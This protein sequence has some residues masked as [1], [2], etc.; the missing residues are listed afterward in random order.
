VGASCQEDL[1][2]NLNDIVEE[3]VGAGIILR[4]WSQRLATDLQ[5]RRD[6]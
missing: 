3:L 4:N 2:A 5:G 1:Y 6:E